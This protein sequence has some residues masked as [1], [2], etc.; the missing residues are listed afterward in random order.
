MYLHKYLTATGLYIL[1]ENLLSF[2]IKKVFAL[3]CAVRTAI[4]VLQVPVRVVAV[5]QFWV[6]CKLVS[7]EIKICFHY[8]LPCPC[9]CF[10]W[11]VKSFD[12]S[13]PGAEFC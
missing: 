7:Y 4:I 10:F 12:I 2:I 3:P 6:G 11:V 9:Y 5:K 13:Q 8:L 1:H